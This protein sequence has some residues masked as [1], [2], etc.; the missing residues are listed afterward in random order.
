MNFTQDTSVKLHIEIKGL[1]DIIKLRDRRIAELE[2][3][4]EG[5]ELEKNIL[6]DKNQRF[7]KKLQKLGKKYGE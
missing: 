6:L 2:E 1:N 4:A 3:D 7:K 5:R